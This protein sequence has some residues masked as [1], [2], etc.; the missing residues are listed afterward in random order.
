MS[1]QRIHIRRGRRTDFAAV[2]QL[3]AAGG[4]PLPPPDRGTMR[5][6]RNIVADLGADFYLAFI[7]G[8]LAGLLHMT[9]ARQ[10]TV[11]ARAQLSQLVVADGFRRR[12][13]G[14]ALL[15]F[16]RRRASQRG[17]ISLSCV[18]PET[19]RAQ[20]FLEKAGLRTVGHCFSLTLA[21]EGQGD[22]PRHQPD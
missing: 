1:D 10:L 22:E 9:Y 17:C 12:G 11:P 18:P 4:I 5:R 6:F 15:A 14:S 2:M 8:A 21:P 3:L 20:S 7:D 19:A 13:V 16:A